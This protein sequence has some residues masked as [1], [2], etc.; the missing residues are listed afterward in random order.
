MR[1]NRGDNYIVSGGDDKSVFV[2]DLR[3][4]KPVNYILASSASI[5]SIDVFEDS[6]VILTTSD[7]G[8]SRVW[9]VHNGECLR[10]VTLSNTPPLTQG[11][12]TKT[13]DVGLFGSLN[14]KITLFNIRTGRVIKEY[15]GHQ[16]TD[17][18][19]D[20][21]FTFDVQGDISGFMSG[22]EDGYLHLFEFD[23][24]TP[25][26]SLL[27]ST[28]RQTLDLMVTEKGRA[29]VAGRSTSGL[30]RVDIE[31]GG[32]RKEERAR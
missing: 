5:T 2:W 27:L 8:Y 1:K 20:L 10:T 18:I 11:R 30:M 24:A 16:N 25:R 21:G 19:L 14:G 4:L 6:S 23:E 7:E 13:S 3:T 29:F 26:E 31:V 17:Y 12:F 9:D 32:G 15:H 22:S 28:E